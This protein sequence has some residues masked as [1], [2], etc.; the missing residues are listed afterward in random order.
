M[1]NRLDASK[2]AFSIVAGQLGV[3]GAI[4]QIEQQ[5]GANSLSS[6]SSH[7]RLALL[8]TKFLDFLSCHA[9]TP[10]HFL[11]QTIEGDF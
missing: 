8:V 11:L 3:F 9:S 7:F 2:Q 5:S 6:L 1:N 4:S 10:L